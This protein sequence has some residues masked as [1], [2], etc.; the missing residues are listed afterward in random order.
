MSTVLSFPEV[1]RKIQYSRGVGVFD[2][3]PRLLSSSSFA[4]FSEAIFTD[5]GETPPPSA[6]VSKDSLQA[7]KRTARL[8]WF[9]APIGGDGRRVSINAEPWPLLVLDIDAIKPDGEQTPKA[10]LLHLI[11][12]V[13]QLAPSFGYTSLSHTDE[14]PRCRLVLHLSRQIS[15]VESKELATLICAQL[16]EKLGVRVLGAAPLDVD[17]GYIVVDASMQ[18]GAHIAFS[19]VNGYKKI[20]LVQNVLPLAVDEWLG[21][22]KSVNSIY[23]TYE[24]I[25]DSRVESK[26]N[27]KPETHNNIEDVR[28][29][30]AVIPPACSR[31]IWRNVGFA[32]RSLNWGCGFDLFHNWSLKAPEKYDEK[33]FNGV[34][35]GSVPSRPDSRSISHR[36]LFQI[37]KAYGYVRRVNN[38]IDAVDSE[39]AK[40]FLDAHSDELIFVLGRGWLSW[41]GSVWGQN[42]ASPNLLAIAFSDQRFEAAKQ[43]LQNDYRDSRLQD[44][45]KT[46]GKLRSRAKRQAMLADAADMARKDANLLD[47]HPHL[48]NVQNGVVDLRT[49][50]LIPSDSSLLLTKQCS[51]PYLRSAPDGA[52]WM[53]ALNRWH[54]GDQSLIDFLQ[55]WLGSAATGVHSRDIVYSVGS[56]ADGKSVIAEIC[57]DIFNSYSTAL[58]RDVITAG[59]ASS[60][61]GPKPEL[62][63]LVGKRFVT[64]AELTGSRTFDAGLLKALSGGD[65]ISASFKFKDNFDFR[66]HIHLHMMGNGL[67]AVKGETAAAFWER[68][69]VLPY[70]NPIPINER[71]PSL[72]EK[73]LAQEGPAILKWI[74]EGAVKW[75]ANGCKLDPPPIVVLATAEYRGDSDPIRQWMADCVES[76]SPNDFTTLADCFGSYEGWAR[77]AGLHRPNKIAYGRALSAIGIA[78]YN[79]RKKGRGRRLKLK[80]NH[81]DG[82]V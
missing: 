38:V 44:A 78:E 76:Q 24:P 8:P 9:S 64:I 54:G 13:R 65:T 60:G 34:W 19:P 80:S 68:L 53:E 31:E 32:I 4:E 6:F 40:D 28:A 14:A 39:F 66:P 11:E 16:S 58:D 55:L 21:N 74:V 20:N 56:G 73:L 50:E 57:H 45:V 22:S 33:D 3:K 71:D 70:R 52:M 23:K 27:F 62:A 75:Y 42:E 77:L 36:T 59:K 81:F 46:A 51:Q 67:P 43:A 15:A 7:F 49:G 63:K 48:L 18:A 10:L 30:L 69:H 37:A 61:Q 29:A 47:A 79:D 1:S 72:R 2:T 5:L 25:D 82:L 17:S 12:A 35:E 26:L 41:T